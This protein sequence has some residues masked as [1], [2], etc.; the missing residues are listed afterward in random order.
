MPE[1]LLKI[2]D[3]LLLT[4]IQALTHKSEQTLW[5][6]AIVLMVVILVISYLLMG[7]YHSLIH[8]VNAINKA[9]ENLGTGNFSQQL[10]VNASDELGDIGKNFSK[11]S[12]RYTNYWLCLVATSVNYVLRQTIFINLLII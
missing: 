1:S 11:C 7:I 4:R 9:A 8:N 2:S 10:L 5:I 12:K 6:L 3:R